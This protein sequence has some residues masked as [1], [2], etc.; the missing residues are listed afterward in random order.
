MQT[1]E[2]INSFM[3]VFQST[4]N[5]TTTHVGARQVNIH[6]FAT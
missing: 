2:A 3:Q 5:K 6:L 1:Y 4:Q